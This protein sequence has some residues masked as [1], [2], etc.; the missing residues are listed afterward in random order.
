MKKK[1]KKVTYSLWRLGRNVIFILPNDLQ[2]LEIK[3]I[4]NM[5]YNN[6]IS[7]TY[8]FGFLAFSWGKK[9]GGR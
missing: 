5:K 9:S 4:A 3:Y 8:T 1:K 6:G 2:F 7:Q